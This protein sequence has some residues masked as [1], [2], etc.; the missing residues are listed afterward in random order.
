MTPYQSEWLK[1]TS[2]EM[3]NI[4]EDAEKKRESGTL[5]HCL[6]ECKLVQPLQKTVWSFHK[7]LKMELP[8]DP[9]IALLGIYPKDTKLLIRRDMCT[10][11]FIAALSTIAKLWQEPKSPPS[12]EWIKMLYMKYYSAIKKE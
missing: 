10:P 4:V 1:L 11:I 12:D 9:A 7:K 8:Y 2:Q 6:W 3:T 5:L